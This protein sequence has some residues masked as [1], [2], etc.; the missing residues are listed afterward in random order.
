MGHDG[1]EIEWEDNM[2]MM[3]KM[4]NDQ[5]MEWKMVDEET[6]KENMDIEWNFKK[7]QFVK[8]EIYNDQKSMHPMQ[9]PVHFH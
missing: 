9:H 2:A 7:G 3:N 8:V 6:K 5:M 1:D 4:S